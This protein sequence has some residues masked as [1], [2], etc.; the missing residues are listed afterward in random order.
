MTTAFNL[1]L[2]S[3]VFLTI[4][5]KK[6]SFFGCSPAQVDHAQER[7]AVTA[8]F[9]LADGL[10]DETDRGFVSRLDNR[11]DAVASV[12]FRATVGWFAHRSSIEPKGPRI[13]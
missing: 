13:I 2:K 5:N 12:S 3:T 4:T 9:L 7:I 1:C 11:L 10:F 6:G 8:G